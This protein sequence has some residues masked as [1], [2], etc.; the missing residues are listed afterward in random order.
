MKKKLLTT[1][2]GSANFPDRQIFLKMR[3][4][5]YLIFLFMIQVSASTGFSQEAKLSLD[6]KNTTVNGALNAIEQQTQYFFL[7]NNKLVDVNRMVSVHCKDAEIGQVLDDLFEGT[8][9]EYI[10]KNRQIILTNQGVAAQQNISVSGK[11]TGSNGE[12]LPG[13]TVAIKGTTQGV[14]TDT[15]GNYSFKSIPANAVLVFSFV[16]LRSVEV[17]V[18]GKSQLDV[19]MEEESIGIEEVVAVGY[20]TQKKKLVTGATAQVKGDDLTK[21]NTV[22]AL[23]ALQSQTA[24]VNI[25]QSNG[26]P[27]EGF[28]VTIRGLGTIGDSSPLYVIDGVAGGDIDVLNP[29]DIESV[30]VLKDAASAAIYGARA[31]NG[32]ILVTTKQGKKG[33]TTVTYDNYVGRQYIS[34]MPDLLNAREYMEIQDRR[35]I[36]DGHASGYDWAGTLPDDLYESVMDGS[37]EGTNWIKEAYKK[38]A[39]TQNHAVNV[40]GGN[41]LSSFSL[42]FSYTQQEGILG[43]NKIDPVNADYNR[44]TARVNSDHVVLKKDKR[45]VVKIGETL[46]FSYTRNNGIQ[47]GDI[48][49]NDVHNYMVASP[50]LPV[51]THDEKGKISGWYDQYAKDEEKWIFDVRE[52][53]PLALSA[54]SSR[55]KNESKRFTLQTSA[56]LQ[57]EPITNLVFKSQFGF[58]FSASAYRSYTSVY[59]LST[60]TEETVDEVSQD[61]GSGLNWTLD[62]TVSYRFTVADRHVFDAV[63]GQSIEKWGFGQDVGASSQK[64]IYSGAG[65]DYAWVS[66]GKPTELSQVDYSGSPWDEGGIASFFGRINYNFKEKYLATVTMRT[67]GS[68]NFARGNRWGYFPSVSAGWVLTEDF[69]KGSNQ[70]D[71]LKLRASWGQNGNCSIDNFQYLSSFSFS[72]SNGYAFDAGKNILATGAIASILANPEVSWETSEQINI[73]MDSRFLN[74][75]L[76]LVVDW[77]KKQTKDWLVRAPIAGVYGLGAP[78][79]NGGDVRNTGIELALNWNEKKG[80]FSYGAGVNL[81]Y[82]ENEVTRIANDEGIIHGPEDVLSEGT[83]EY[84]RCEVGK[85]IGF[86]W[87]YKTAGIFQ[88]EAQVNATEAKLSGAQPGDVIFVDATGD[89]EITEDDRTMIGDPNPDFILGF[90]LNMQYKGFDFSVTGRGAFGQQI[91]K[92]Y[93]SFG[94]SP[95][96][97]YTRDVY[98]TWNGEGTSNKLPKLNSGSYTNWMM[99][100]DIYLEKGDY[101]KISNLTV[102]YD[103]NKLIRNSPFGKLRLYFSANNLI[104]LTNYSG[105]DPEIGYGFEDSS[106]MSGIDLGSYPSSS[107]YLLGI[108]I[109]FN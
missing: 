6:L 23:G 46:N 92:S 78:Y 60:Q 62:N 74:N 87:G 37:W 16:G 12:S 30:D 53:N 99:L 7:F 101:V 36:N 29:S 82:N 1:R 68:S 59:Y 38:G 103:F 105:M 106:W 9:V 49:W 31:A 14:I 65:F 107:S 94:D 104:T 27:G 88:N 75:R 10:I 2:S 96:Q 18:A 72:D 21:L 20:G 15:S 85:P 19:Q 89:G 47:Q 91:A 64:T 67:D 13:V 79:I 40:A 69:L 84:Y 24:G 61:A 11:V 98:D 58:K 70:L 25:L 52:A 3:V 71:F 102:G 41:E 66:N 51:Y 39:P 109:Q 28:K 26:Q 57:I 34:K 77:Y 5:L 93:R 86:F 22:S 76:G 4:T 54:L 83:G 32:V 100:S 35:Y 33:K 81:T 73:G 48:Y 43:W 44:Y 56:Y 8:D 95:L 97:N 50:L 90:N 108:N 17:P 55:G 45:D 42:G 80:D 63:I